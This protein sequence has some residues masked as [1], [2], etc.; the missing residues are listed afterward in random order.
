MAKDATPL[1][2]MLFFFWKHKH[3]D[4]HKRTAHNDSVSHSENGV[5]YRL[6]N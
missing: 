2:W 4:I 5:F 3:T 1:D 6:E